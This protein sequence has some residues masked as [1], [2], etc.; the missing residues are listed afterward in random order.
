MN[1]TVIQADYFNPQHKK[2]ILHLLDAYATDPMGGGKALDPK[3]PL[4]SS[5]LK[6]V[7]RIY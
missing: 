7:M 6:V 2:D 4:V 5:K 1:I 3:V